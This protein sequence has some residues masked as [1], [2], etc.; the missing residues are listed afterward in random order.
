M[1]FPKLTNLFHRRVRS[2]PEIYRLASA[3]LGT[4]EA[5]PA[6]TECIFDLALPPASSYDIHAFASSTSNAPSEFSQY[7]L[8][9]A[10]STSIH[11]PLA[12]QHLSAH[13]IQ[14]TSTTLSSHFRYPAADV[15]THHHS[16]VAILTERI[17]DLETALLD[18]C[19]ASS[20]L[21]DLQE[22]LHTERAAREE[23]EAAKVTL[24][25][26]VVTLQAEVL[27]LR[28]VLFASVASEPPAQAQETTSLSLVSERDRLRHFCGLVISMDAH[29][30]VLDAAYRSVVQGE[31]AEAALV[32]A[33]KRAVAQPESVWRGL[34][35]PVTGPRTQNQYL[36]QVRCTL[37]A[38]RQIQDWR[39]RAKFWKSTA[40]DGGR[41]VDTVTPSVSAI[42]DVVDALPNERKERVR[43]M[44]DRLENG[45]LPLRVSPLAICEAPS[46]ETA[47]RVPQSMSSSSDVQTDIDAIARLVEVA[48]STPPD[49]SLP[50]TSSSMVL[51]SF[52]SSSTAR[53][54]LA[55]SNLP[56]LASETFRASHSIKSIASR[57]SP[58]RTSIPP[59]GSTST[60]ASMKSRRRHAHVL[61]LPRASPS[62]SSTSPEPTV[63]VASP[64]GESATQ[65][66]L[67]AFNSLPRALVDFGRG[68]DEDLV[69]VLSTD[70][71][72]TSYCMSPQQ[73]A[74]ARASS[75]FSDEG[76]AHA[77]ASELAAE[78]KSLLPVRMPGLKAIKRLSASIAGS[79]GALTETTN[80]QGELL[81]WKEE[82]A[83]GRT[84]ALS[85]GSQKVPVVAAV[86]PPRPAKLPMGRR[87]QKFGLGGMGDGRK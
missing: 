19:E 83:G 38:R 39:K 55:Q 58:Q 3:P 74:S 60:Q 13:S 10:S 44:M 42:S 28:R 41:H 62:S 79:R 40:R 71:S 35:E 47:T 67:P 8:D 66:T 17:H 12:G 18:E 56:P 7:T 1:R 51:P 29:K 81:P 34:L 16:V 6:S 70:F 82:G 37:D 84:R 63:F 49:V 45:E 2:D 64:S 43:E 50:A 76:G 25:E 20:C 31:D 21:P 32:N 46:D 9:P 15:A 23:A 87:L 22:A 27:Q 86:S 53:I 69:L 59:S 33:I 24:A 5:R 72:E 73:R 65:T 85:V 57:G 36:A 14:S 77:H 80:A 54:S 61:T 48:D 4:L 52:N 68:S 11:R 78:K 30:P 26:Q 75:P